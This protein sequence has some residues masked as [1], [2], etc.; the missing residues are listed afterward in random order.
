[1]S[2]SSVSRLIISE[3]NIYTWTT[4]PT[5]FFDLEAEARVQRIGDDTLSFQ[6]NGS[7]QDGTTF[8]GSA[9]S[10]CNGVMMKLYES[11]DI[12]QWDE[13]SETSNEVNIWNLTVAINLSFEGSIVKENS[14]TVNSTEAATS[15]WAA[16]YARGPDF[17][18]A[19]I[20]SKSMQKGTRR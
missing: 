8:V 7:T 5:V 14:T 13:A 2:R 9:S 15:V 6:M 4:T 10:S 1:M 12:L 3:G 16:S 20:S 11:S 18:S 17:M 19:P